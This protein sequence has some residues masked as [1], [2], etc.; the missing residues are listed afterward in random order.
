MAN[1]EGK[2]ILTP[3]GARKLEARLE[4]L[5]TV[6]RPAVH[7]EINIARGFGDLSEN[8]EYTAARERQG[9]IEGEIQEIEEK[10]RKAIIVE[11]N[12]M[13]GDVAS[14]GCS[15]R[16]YDME[17][18]EEDVY[19]LVGATEAD[20]RQLFVSNESPIGS[21]LIGARVGDVVT[22]QTPGGQIQLKILEITR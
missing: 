16:V 3:D 2:V 4:E 18:K 17:Y 11:E 22:A 7:E 19:K 6:E 12:E 20:P 15:V 21:A 8:A 13:N 14:L 5:K 9:R 1:E 10:L